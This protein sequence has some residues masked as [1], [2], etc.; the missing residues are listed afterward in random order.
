MRLKVSDEMLA[1]RS[2][3]T[4]AVRGLRQETQ[5]RGVVGRELERARSTRTSAT[6][7]TRE[8]DADHGACAARRAQSSRTSASGMRA[9]LTQRLD[10]VGELLHALGLRLGLRPGE[11]GG[12]AR[13]SACVAAAPERAR[14]QAERPPAIGRRPSARR[15]DE[16]ERARERVGLAA[17]AAHARGADARP[18]RA[19][20]RRAARAARRPRTAAR[21]PGAGEKR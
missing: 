1:E 2:S 7:A 3:T 6:S 10:P 18:A 5:R 21:A 8:H 15:A 11:V 9:L 17:R 20:R 16:R 13:P 19:A 14:E 4:I 12:G